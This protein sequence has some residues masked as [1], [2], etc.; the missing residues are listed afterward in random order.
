MENE[1]LLI[2]KNYDGWKIPRFTT[3]QALDLFH[4]WGYKIIS[5]DGKGVVHDK[6][7]DSGGEVRYGNPHD[8]ECEI[9]LAI[10]EGDTLPERVDSEEAI[11]MEYQRVFNRE[12]KTR[13]FK[14]L[15]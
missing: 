1:L 14:L 10:K 6:Y 11:S 13:L 5:H 8:S 9:I 12:I 3:E 4:S 15:L 7:C 2:S